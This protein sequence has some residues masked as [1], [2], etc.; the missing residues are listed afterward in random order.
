MKIINTDLQARAVVQL[1]TATALFFA[2][3]LIFG[4]RLLEPTQQLLYH[5]ISSSFQ[6]MMLS[7]GGAVLLRCYKRGKASYH[8]VASVIA[9]IGVLAALDALIFNSYFD[10]FNS[11]IPFYVY[12][13]LLPLALSLIPILPAAEQ[14]SA[15]QQR[16]IQVSASYGLVVFSVALTFFILHLLLKSPLL[17][18]HPTG[19]LIICVAGMVA[20]VAVYGTHYR[21]RRPLPKLSRASSSF[22]SLTLFAVLLFGVG[23]FHSEMS[24]LKQQ[25]NS[26]I[27]LLRDSRA[28]LGMS[29]MKLFERLG[30]R[31]QLYPFEQHSRLMEVDISSYLQQVEFLEALMLVSPDQRV[32]FE[33][34]KP[35]RS[36]YLE[37]A[38]ADPVIRA[39]LEQ[40]SRD[41]R[42]LLPAF[43]MSGH[44][45]KVVIAVPVDFIEAEG[46]ID[47]G[48]YNLLAV[49][50][51]RSM[52]DTTLVNDM[53]TDI[54]TYTEVKPGVWMDRSG[55]WVKDSTFDY[56]Q[57]SA[58][59]LTSEVINMYYSQE[60][61]AT[62]YLYKLDSLQETSNLQML[63][64]VGGIGLVLLVVLAVERNSTLEIQSRQLSYQAHHDALTGLMN[65]SSI[66]HYIGEHFYATQ[67][68]TVLF[69]DLDGFTLINDSL[70]LHVGDAILVQLA[71]RLHGQQP[72]RSE[73]ARFASDEFILVLQGAVNFPERVSTLA[74]DIMA[75][76]AQP[77]HIGEHKIYLTASVGVAHQTGSVKTPLELIQRADMAMHQ[78][79]RLGYNHVQEYDKSMAQRLLSTTAMRSGL[80]EAIEHDELQLH[81]QPIVR[82][83]DRQSVQV[84]ALLR[85][86]QSDGSY[87]PPS[88]FIPVAE[89][90][91]QIVPLSEW[92]FRQAFS[93]AVKLQETETPQRVSINVSALH[94]NRANFVDFVLQTLAE[95]GCRAQWVELELTESILLEGTQ[96]A[97]DRLHTLREHGLT[98]A[99]DD[100]GTGFSSLSYLKRLPI[101]IVKIDRSFIAGIDRHRSDRVLI[102]SVI[103]IAQ[104]LDFAVLAEGIETKEQ[105]D[106]VTDLGCNYMQGY[107]FG[108]PLPLKTL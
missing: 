107:Y 7:I 22:T 70:G 35:S 41:T 5:S 11:Q 59:R 98:I 10:S 69:I 19:S 95:T 12:L 89:M 9:L 103:N 23:M 8:R 67:D 37:D 21:G 84:E 108:R 79:K 49:L 78:A 102:N 56:L 47:S 88:E 90:T 33:R 74:H 101:D 91:G 42:M 15:W 97:I 13:A 99:L 16:F 100:F 66:E 81:Y 32:V 87:I 20:G 26:S 14:R 27:K 83:N 38:M 51:V 57:D 82:C 71:E 18:K 75:T 48:L 61:P 45:A 96:Y 39:A 52:L 46:A 3:L 55:F 25:G 65:R 62:A 43:G 30:E 36:S 68:V 94:F 105:A 24:E 29:T 77:Y 80:Q 4:Y 54:E 40:K 85:W 72:R 44:S 6:I 92:V 28:T 76:V 86:R 34:L 31:W 64:V 106:F 58:L 17:A 73:L 1:V 53:E 2:G 60:I 50:D 63:V 93:D 104:S